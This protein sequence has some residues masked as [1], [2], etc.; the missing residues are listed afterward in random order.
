M[1]DLDRDTLFHLF[2]KILKELRF[3]DSPKMKETVS[4]VKR[5]SLSQPQTHPGR[6]P[7]LRKSNKFK[8][9]WTTSSKRTQKKMT[10]IHRKRPMRK[11]QFVK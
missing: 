10:R 2:D 3:Q 11:S 5:R 8:K 9:R 7:S 1:S 6:K 4:M